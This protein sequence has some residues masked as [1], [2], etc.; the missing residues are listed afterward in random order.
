MVE[1]ALLLVFVLPPILFGIIQFGLI[2]NGQVS[3]THAAREG[4]RAAALGETYENVRTKVINAASSTGFVNISESSIVITPA[5]ALDRVVG[6]ETKV[7]VNG[8][9]DIVVPFLNRIIGDTF[10]LSSVASMRIEVGQ[11]ASGGPGAPEYLGVSSINPTKVVNDLNVTITLDR[12][13]QGADVNIRI[14]QQ[15]GSLY[16]GGIPGTTNSSGIAVI[17]V[18]RFFHQI[19][20]A[21]DGNYIIV[22]TNVNKLGYTWDGNPINQGFNK[23]GSF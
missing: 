16:A 11:L 17:E 12:P 19:H 3:M 13:I 20:G 21:P 5:N 23:P 22:I 4:V 7:T 10:P 1:F 15:D 6:E 9:V 2:F 8:S 14:D 18:A